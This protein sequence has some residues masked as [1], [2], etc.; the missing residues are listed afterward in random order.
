MNIESIKDYQF[1]DFVEEY[2]GY[3]MKGSGTIVS[4]QRTENQVVLN[5]K[6]F[7]LNSVIKYEFVFSNDKCIVSKNYWNNVDLTKEWLNF[8]EYLSEVTY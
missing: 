4:L 5:F 7:K 8:A 1:Y 3:P 6:K 2:L